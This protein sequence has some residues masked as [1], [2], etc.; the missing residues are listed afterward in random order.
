MFS[1]NAKKASKQPEPIGYLGDM[2][3]FQ[4]ECLAQLK[5][6]IQNNGIILNP[7]FSDMYLLRFCRA[8]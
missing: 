3:E 5:L 2:S 6:H 4:S 7:W 8:R 1:S